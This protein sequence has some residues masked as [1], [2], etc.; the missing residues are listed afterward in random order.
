MRFEWPVPTGINIILVMLWKGWA[1]EVFD[2][3]LFGSKEEE[4]GENIF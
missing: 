4:K 2:V 3:C 1:S